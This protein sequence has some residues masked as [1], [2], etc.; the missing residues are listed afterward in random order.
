MKKIIAFALLLSSLFTLVACS[1]RYA[2]IEVIGEEVKYDESWGNYV[3]IHPDEN[4]KWEYQIKWSIYPNAISDSRVEFS[5]DSH[6]LDATVDQDGKVTFGSIG[7]ITV[8]LS[9]KRSDAT[10]TLTVIARN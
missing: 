1:S 5:Y 10:A 2:T 3:V 4:G 7:M 8:T 6:G 9:V